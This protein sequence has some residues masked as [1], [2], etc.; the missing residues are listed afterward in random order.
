MKMS[1][2]AGVRLF[3]A[4]S[5][6]VIAPS[7]LAQS[8]ADPPLGTSDAG[9][10]QLTYR[11][12]NLMR[13]AHRR[14]LV[15]DARQGR[16]YGWAI[17]VT[18]AV[19]T[20]SVIVA[21]V[22]NDDQLR[23]LEIL[24]IDGDAFDS[25]LLAPMRDEDGYCGVLRTAELIPGGCPPVLVVRPLEIEVFVNV[26]AIATPIATTLDLPADARPG[27]VQLLFPPPNP[28]EPVDPILRVSTPRIR[29][30]P[31]DTVFLFTYRGL[32]VISAV[33]SLSSPIDGT[34]VD[35]FP[36]PGHFFT[37]FVF[38]N[39]EIGWD[40]S[41]LKR[42]RQGTAASY[43]VTHLRYTPLYDRRAFLDPRS[44]LT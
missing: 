31:T 11:G 8:A 35:Y 41:W 27:R 36:A 17:K 5:V 1:L 44:G 30:L 23:P 24:K 32:R 33:R 22:R 18:T 19:K 25:F 40:E 13:A 9:G 28:A 6:A 2:S 12:T 15:A 42:N 7:A 16:S 3:F 38:E 39:R 29:K 14:P 37:S 21:V 34:D 10:M 20:D 26:S 43:V 4:F